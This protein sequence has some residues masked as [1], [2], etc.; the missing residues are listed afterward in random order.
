MHHTL[1]DNTLVLSVFQIIYLGAPSRLLDHLWF[2]YDR[3]H[4]SPPT[5]TAWTEFHATMMESYRS[6]GV[7]VSLCI[8]IGIL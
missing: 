8:I 2:A 5:D 4:S 7:M 6:Y 3:Y 1:G